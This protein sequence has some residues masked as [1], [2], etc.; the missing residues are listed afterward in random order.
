M[1]G[2]EAA[3]GDAGAA[4]GII[5]LGVLNSKAVLLEFFSFQRGYSDFQA[6]FVPFFVAKCWIFTKIV[7]F[8][9]AKDG[10]E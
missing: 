9:R 3:L 7:V 8:W 1:D 2:V 4:H 5:R 10:A 6:A